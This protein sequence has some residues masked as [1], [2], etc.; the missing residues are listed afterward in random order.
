MKSTTLPRGGCAESGVAPEG[1]TG[2]IDGVAAR[3]LEL[4]GFMLVRKGRVVAEGAWKPYAIERPHMLFSLSKSFTS[5]AVGFAVSEGLVSLEAPV[6]SFFP[7]E[8][9]AAVSKN[10]AAMKVRHLLTMGSG[11]ETDTMERILGTEDWVRAFLGLEVELEPGSRF[12][13]N[14]GA[15]YMLSAILRKVTGKGL[16]DYLMPRLFHPLGI[17]RPTWAACPKGIECGGWGLELPLEAIAKFGTLYLNKGIWNGVRVIPEGWVEEATSSHIDNS[18]GRTEDW[19]QGY[20]YQFWRS[21]HGAYRG[22]GA[23]G[24]FCLVMPGEDAVLA[25]TSGVPDMQGVLDAVWESILPALGKAPLAPNEAAEKAL[26]TRLASLSYAPVSDKAEAAG[27]PSAPGAAVGSESSW[28][29]E[30]NEMNIGSIR[31][32][33]ARDSGCVAYGDGNGTHLVAFGFGFW[34]E[35]ETDGFGA[36]GPLAHTT[37]GMVPVAASGVWR[38]D[39]TLVMVVRFLAQPFVQTYSFRFSADRLTIEGTVNVTSGPPGIPT[40]T[41]KRLV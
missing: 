38:D 33:L 27:S 18:P 5:T 6:V 37:K 20:G 39:S 35:G 14:S 25:I 3:G 41:A 19:A 10:L 21:K 34:K 13:Y 7:D 9:P 11:H 26:R 17:E 15:T 31:F 4:H 23:F 29:V 30:R 8:V 1:I 22:D 28:T 12:V 24:Q 36:V 16:T 40:L 32:S 2:F